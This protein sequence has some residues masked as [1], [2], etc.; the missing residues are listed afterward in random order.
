MAIGQIDG[1]TLHVA[2]GAPGELVEARIDHRSPHRPDAWG[3]ITS[4]LEPSADRVTPACPSYGPCGGCRLEHLAYPAQVAWKSSLSRALLKM[5]TDECVPSPLP[6]GYRN[7]EKRVFAV[8]G[9]KK[10]LGAYLPRSHEVVDLA[11]CRVSQ[12]PLDEVATAIAPQ[13]ENTRYVILR[14]NHLGQVLVMVVTADRTPPQLELPKE[15]VGLVQNVNSST[16]NVL[17]GEETIPL[18]GAT[19]LEDRV[20]DVRLHLSPTAFFQVNR[21]I[22]SRIYSDALEWAELDGSERVLDVYCGVGGLAL[23]MAPRAKQVLGIEAHAPSIEDA[24]KSAAL[25]QTKN[26][27][28]RVGDAA[29]LDEKADVVILNPPRKGCSPRLLQKL[30]AERLLYVSCYPETLARDLEILKPRYRVERVRPY[31]MLPQTPHVELLAR[32]TRV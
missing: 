19:F 13:L 18:E 9:G 12:P 11:G 3:T 22:A 25:N 29:E 8:L 27:H 31:D 32:L 15:V 24:Q 26:A 17:V 2:G 10:V 28:F 7:R 6:Y 21:E 4:I 5:E 20:N 23:T 30:E 1:T 16:G 14:V